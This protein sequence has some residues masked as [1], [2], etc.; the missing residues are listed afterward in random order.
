MRNM[1]PGNKPVRFAPSALKWTLMEPFSPPPTL[2]GPPEQPLHEAQPDADA[3]PPSEG[4]LAPLDGDWLGVVFN[5]RS[6]HS[7]SLSH[8]GGGGGGVGLV[9]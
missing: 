9:A 8:G 1:P 4:L 2:I 5:S 7:T 3:P 6:Q